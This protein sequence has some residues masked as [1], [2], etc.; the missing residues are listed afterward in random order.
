MVHLFHQLDKQCWQFAP[1]SRSCG[2]RL[3]QGSVQVVLMSNNLQATHVDK[4]GQILQG[5]VFTN[6]VLPGFPEG[7]YFE[8]SYA[9]LGAHGFEFLRLA[10]H[11]AG[12]WQSCTKT[13]KKLKKTQKTNTHNLLKAWPSL[14]P[15]ENLG[16][17]NKKNIIWRSWSSKKQKNIGKQ[18]QNNDL[19]A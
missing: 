5:A 7:E 18:Q 2:A 19:K 8:V 3:G 16:K 15:K 17:K 4:T 9:D 14:N 1:E 11:G 10:R 6:G 13:K 12:R